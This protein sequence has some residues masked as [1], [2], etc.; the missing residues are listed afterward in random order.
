MT[1]GKPGRPWREI[2]NCSDHGVRSGDLPAFRTLSLRHLVSPS[3]LPPER[4]S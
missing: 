1:F 4:G 2:L 3:P